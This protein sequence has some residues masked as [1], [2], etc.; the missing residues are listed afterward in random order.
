MALRLLQEA[1]KEG[2]ELRAALVAAETEALRLQAENRHLRA[3]LGLEDSAALGSPGAGHPGPD[4]TGAAGSSLAAEAGVDKAG[5][6]GGKAA[7]ADG[8]TEQGS[9][10]PP[11]AETTATAA[12]AADPGSPDAKASRRKRLV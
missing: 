6:G 4:G 9:D 11:A 3:Q 10:P 8:S 2:T 12:P 5:A 1:Q 7:G